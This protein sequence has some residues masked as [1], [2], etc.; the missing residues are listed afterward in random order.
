MSDSTCIWT[1]VSYA[2]VLTRVS[3][4]TPVHLGVCQDTPLHG[5]CLQTSFIKELAM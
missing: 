4:Y 2:R 1:H 3:F 5:P